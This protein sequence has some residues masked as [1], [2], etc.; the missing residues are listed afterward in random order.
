VQ[1]LNQAFSI[2]HFTVITSLAKQKDLKGKTL[3]KIVKV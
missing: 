1:S 3:A 2:N